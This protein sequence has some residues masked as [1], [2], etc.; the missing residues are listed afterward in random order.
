MVG[1]RST[2]TGIQDYSRQPRNRH[3]PDAHSQ[4]PYL[5]D[6]KMS[7]RLSFNL[8]YS[9][10]ILLTCL[11]CNSWDYDWHVDYVDYFV[12]TIYT[13][14]AKL[15]DTTGIWPDRIEEPSTRQA[16]FWHFFFWWTSLKNLFIRRGG[17]Q[18]KLIT[19]SSLSLIRILETG[20]H[21]LL[22]L[23]LIY[24]NTKQTRM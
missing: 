19:T 16:L 3:I 17:H 10:I 24:N 21:I 4:V 6:D 22:C 13:L 15:M 8:L 20:N 2:S 11:L 1:V 18:S 23:A 7:T 14:S 9:P 12:L 5:R